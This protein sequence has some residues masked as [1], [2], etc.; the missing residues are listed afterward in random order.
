MQVLRR[1]PGQPVA[2]HDRLGRQHKLPGPR[3][4]AHALQPIL[5]PRR[6]SARPAKHLKA[7]LRRPVAVRP[8]RQVLEHHIGRAPIRGRRPLDHLD[9][10]IGRLIHPAAMHPHRHARQVHRSPV[11]PDSPDPVD[12]ALAQG[13]S[14][15]Q[16]IV[17]LHRPR[18]AL[19]AGR[20]V[21]P[22]QKPRGPD[23]L[24][25]HPRP[26]EHTGHGRAF[27]GALHL[28]RL[29]AW[30]PLSGRLEAGNRPLVDRAPQRCADCR[31]DRA[32]DRL[33]DAA[34]DHLRHAQASPVCSTPGQRNA[35]TSLRRHHDPIQLSTTVR[36]Q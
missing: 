35:A 19:A 32:A 4:Q 36:P 9:Q 27:R 18:P 12:L 16:R 33:A 25:G 14:E 24:T 5:Q 13:H 15:A 1:R 28:Q 22:L 34:Q 11:G 8:Q 3:D 2:P 10:R 7:Q 23:H 26:P 30:S 29:Q 31:P 21:A 6:I 17:V 20:G